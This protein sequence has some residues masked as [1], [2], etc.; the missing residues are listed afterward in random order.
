AAENGQYWAMRLLLELRQNIDINSRDQQY[1]TPF[2]VAAGKGYKAVVRHLL[3]H[4]A[5]DISSKDEEGQTALSLASENGYRT[6][7]R[8][9]LE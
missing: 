2:I 8:M 9:L 7:V 1:R 4:D 3:Q 5:V 6:V